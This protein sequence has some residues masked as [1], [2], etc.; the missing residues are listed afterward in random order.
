M[1]MSPVNS[2]LYPWP[3]LLAVL[4]RK[5]ESFAFPTFPIRATPSTGSRRGGTADALWKLV[6]ATPEYTGSDA[7]HDAPKGR[8]LVMR[9][10]ADIEPEP[11]KWVWPG[12]IAKGKH[13][14][15]AGEPGIAKSQLALDF[16]AT[17]TKGGLWPHGEGQAPCGRVILLSAED[18]A[19]DTIVP[20][21]MA[22]KADR[23]LVQIIHAVQ[24]EGGKGQHTFNLQTRSRFAR[25]RDQEIR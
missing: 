17:L 23:S 9:C 3:R 25:S 24:N 18:G 12:R 7:K 5:Y 6:E 8:S 16:V 22:A 1:P 10:A 2:M 15:I 13:T 21:L 4:P 19:A 14:A 20:R 11:I